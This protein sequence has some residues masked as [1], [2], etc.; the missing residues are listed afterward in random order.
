MVSAQPHPSRPASDP[1]DWTAALEQNI[2]TGGVPGQG[3]SNPLAMLAVENTALRERLE[4]ATAE[5]DAANDAVVELIGQLE[6]A[7][8]PITSIAA[9]TGVQAK[10]AAKGRV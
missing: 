1:A 3:K 5:L 9:P 6:E 7:G 2:L 4:S 8:V 10:N